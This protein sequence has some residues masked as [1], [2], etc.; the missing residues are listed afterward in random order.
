MRWVI[1]CRSLY[2]IIGQRIKFKITHSPGDGR[3]NPKRAGVYFIRTEWK[4]GRY[5]FSWHK[6]GI[7]NPGS[8]TD[9]FSSGNRIVSYRREIRIREGNVTLTNVNSC[10]HSRRIELL[11]LSRDSR[12]P[13]LPVPRTLRP[14]VNQIALAS[15]MHIHGKR[16]ADYTGFVAPRLSKKG[17]LHPSKRGSE[18]IYPRRNDVVNAHDIRYFRPSSSLFIP[19]YDFHVR[20]SLSLS[21]SF[22]HSPY[23]V[24]VRV[25]TDGIRSTCEPLERST[26]DETDKLFRFFCDGTVTVSW[27]SRVSYEIWQRDNRVLSPESKLRREECLEWSRGRKRCFR[28]WIVYKRFPSIPNFSI[29]FITRVRK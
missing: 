28:N 11:W 27:D 8:A 12:S 2:R 24:I 25:P 1:R 5:R 13:P 22:I 4:T 23:F 19:S 18:H 20:A 14:I 16:M 21:L 17:V 6:K 29:I 7:F 10:P 3:N 15:Q 26:S 9:L